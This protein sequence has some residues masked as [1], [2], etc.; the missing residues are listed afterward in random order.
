MQ[1][2]EITQNYINHVALVLDASGSMRHRKDAVIKVADAQIAHLAQR[3]RELDQETRVTLYLFNDKVTCLTYDK[4]VLRLPS[5]A[6]SYRPDGQTALID[7]AIQSQQDLDKTPELYGD[8]A[9]L[10][11]ILT[12]GQENHSRNRADKLMQVLDALAANRTVAVFVPDQSCKFE[13]KKFGFPAENI[14]IWDA[15][16]ARGVEEV[17]SRI[18][19]TTDSF[20]SLRS[21]GMRGSRNIF[22][23]GL[24][25]VNA[26]TVRS[27]LRPLTPHQY[28][29]IGVKNRKDMDIRTFVEQVGG[30]DYVIGRSFYQLMKTEE[31]QRQKLV[32]VREKR[33]G[34]VFGGPEARDLIGLPRDVTVK[35]KPDWNPEYDVFVQ[36]TSVNRKLVPGTDL[37]VLA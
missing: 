36:S 31:I 22:S 29:M 28:H 13:A 20:M 23:I 30:I 12:D 15:N 26:Q 19:E 25:N 11:Y 35:V 1:I 2:G 9:F 33:T 18:R 21:T 17:G 14:A 16:S 32:L 34:N 7:A 5:I 4:D 3:S 37:I 10:T 24:A 27:A 8:H 6:G